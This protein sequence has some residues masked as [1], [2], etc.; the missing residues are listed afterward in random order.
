[1][2]SETLITLWTGSPALCQQT[3]FSVVLDR[4][5]LPRRKLNGSLYE[6]G[7]ANHRFI[8]YI[9]NHRSLHGEWQSYKTLDKALEQASLLERRSLQSDRRDE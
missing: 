7:C 8:H 6:L 1:M 4:D 3:D 5:Y 2:E 9:D